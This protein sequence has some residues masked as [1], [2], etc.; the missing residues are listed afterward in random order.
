VVEENVRPE[1]LTVGYAYVQLVDMQGRMTCSSQHG[2]APWSSPMMMMMMMM[3][4][5]MSYRQTALNAAG[6][7]HVY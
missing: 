2:Y 4:I 1:P 5:M 3:T 6:L 7:H